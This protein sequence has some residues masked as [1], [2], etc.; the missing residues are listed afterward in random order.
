MTPPAGGP[1]PVDPVVGP[2]AADDDGDEADRQPPRPQQI[3]ADACPVREAPQQ[4]FPSWRG[5]R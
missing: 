1:D 5:V 2:V 3:H 4:S